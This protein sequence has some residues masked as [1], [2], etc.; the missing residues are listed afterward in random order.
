MYRETNK[1]TK[2]E[3]I[4]AFLT[5]QL[6]DLDFITK[7]FPSTIPIDLVCPVKSRLHAPDDHPFNMMRVNVTHYPRR[8]QGTLIISIIMLVI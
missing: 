6:Y 1:T 4:Y 5:T 8:M 2:S 7:Y 3:L